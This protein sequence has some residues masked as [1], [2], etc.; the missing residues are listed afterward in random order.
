M[1]SKMK[2]LLINPNQVCVMDDPTQEGFG[3]YDKDNCIKM[4]MRGIVYYTK[5]RVP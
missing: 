2:H 5:T 3:M 1:G 4:K